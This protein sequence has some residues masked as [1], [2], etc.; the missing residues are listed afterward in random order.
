MKKKRN[1]L[2]LLGIN[3]PLEKPTS[4]SHY[5]S[6]KQNYISVIISLY[7]CT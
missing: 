7:H 3:G 1:D 2:D 5:I 6:T 4:V